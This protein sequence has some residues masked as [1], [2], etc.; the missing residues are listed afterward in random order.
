MPIKNQ[1]RFAPAL[2][3]VHEERLYKLDGNNVVPSRWR[4]TVD[5]FGAELYASSERYRIVR[6]ADLV[7]ALDL[8]SDDLGVELEAASAMYKNGRSRFR[9]FF[10]DSF[11]VPG[12]PSDIRPQIE[13]G[14]D[15][16]GGSGVRV[17]AGVYR[18]V[19]TNGLVI[20]DVSFQSNRRHTGEF[21]LM[22]YML[23]AMQAMQDRI[24]KVENLS[25]RAAE[26]PLPADSP[27]TCQ[28]LEDTVPRYRSRL[29]EAIWRNG[30]EVG[31]TVW[32]LLQ[33]IS[34]VKTH[35]MK[36]RWSATDW[37]SR[38]TARVLELIA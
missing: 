27:V 29:H 7:A 6:N 36:D 31:G 3:D 18:L 34:E 12:D 15:Y 9:A 38:Q 13:L 23:A 10:P 19:C 37:Q 22:E 32:A 20:G 30:D 17:T 25:R 14:N 26:T 33:A 24:V 5:D 28:I 1:D 16:R 35:D 11:R 4:Q 8:A 21:D 2:V